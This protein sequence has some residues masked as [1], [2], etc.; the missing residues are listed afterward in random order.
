[1]DSDHWK[2]RVWT[3][4]QDKSLRGSSPATLKISHDKK[5]GSEKMDEC[6]VLIVFNAV[7]ILF[8]LMFLCMSVKRHPA[9]LVKDFK[10]VMDVNKLNCS[11][12]PTNPSLNLTVNYR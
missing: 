11:W 12:I 5:K 3:M 8:K 9:E 10:C 4:S 6:F 2:F 1:M 7:M